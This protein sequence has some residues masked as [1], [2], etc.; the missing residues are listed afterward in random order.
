M[1]L[2]NVKIF[3]IQLYLSTALNTDETTPLGFVFYNLIIPTISLIILKA[4]MN[5]L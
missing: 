4:G 3:N 2:L 1:F 5:L